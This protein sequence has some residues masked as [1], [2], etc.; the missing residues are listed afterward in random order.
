MSVEDMALAA[1]YSSWSEEYW[2]ASWMGGEQSAA[3][4][5][6][7]LRG[8]H[9]E[10]LDSYQIETLAHVRRLLGLPGTGAGVTPENAPSREGDAAPG[11]DYKTG[12]A[13]C[14][15]RTCDESCCDVCSDPQCQ[16]N[17]KPL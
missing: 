13:K 7:W 5:V 3:E 11:P 8:A 10:R 6:E 14:G 4:F 1:L 2:A 9:R 15:K 17:N 16:H 12:C